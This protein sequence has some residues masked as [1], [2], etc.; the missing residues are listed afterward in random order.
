VA[1][2]ENLGEGLSINVGIIGGGW[3]GLAAGA[4]LAAKMI[5]VTVF[6]AAPE[7]GG[8]ARKINYNN[9]DLDNGQHILL[10]A[11]SECL[12]L[13]KLC[14]ADETALLRLPL[15]F[16]FHRKFS[17]KAPRLPAPFDLAG[18][19]LSAKGLTWAEKFS[20]VRF[21]A[22]MRLRHFKLVKDATVT[23]LLDQH[24]QHG[25][26]RNF[27]WEP[28][29]V[30]ALN[31]PLD[32]AS[33]QIFLNVL[34][35]GL[36]GGT[37]ASDL[38]VPVKN[39]TEVFPQAAARYIAEQGGAVINGAQVSAIKPNGENFSVTTR[40]GEGNFTHIICA[41]GPHQLAYLIE[42][43]PS[44]QVI[45]RQLDSLQYEPIVTVYIKY[46]QLVTLEQPMT[47]LQGGVVQWLFDRETLSGHKGLLAAVISA[48]GA[49]RELSS[50]ALAREVQQ[51]IAQAFPQLG[52]ALWSKVITEKRATFSC[53][54][55]LTRPTNTTPLKN[56]YLAGDYTHSDYPATLEAAVR[57]GVKCAQLIL[58]SEHHS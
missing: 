18:A 5:P 52:Q 41:A 31:T 14:G 29:C 26:L 7:L 11:Y 46:N 36:F 49:H 56:F 10:G 39:L 15:Q 23:A 33:A 4:E 9:L 13:M 43:F 38:L 32:M 8:R 54:P 16:V 53:T 2:V 1:G 57:S 55:N 6:E 19:M 24:Q 40:D 27:L 44:L 51:E 20:A 12:R 45:S 35:D 17:L 42:T 30:S 21:M 47:G 50:E 25:A 58:A 22:A 28:L 3:A 37:G 48:S 34:R